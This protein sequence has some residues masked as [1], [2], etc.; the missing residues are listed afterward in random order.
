MLQKAKQKVNKFVPV[1]DRAKIWK[2]R[3]IL[4]KMSC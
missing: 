4:Y 1:T 3:N 2:E